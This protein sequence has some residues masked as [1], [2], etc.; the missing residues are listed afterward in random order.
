MNRLTNSFCNSFWKNKINNSEKRG[1]VHSLS[2]RAGRS[3]FILLVWVWIQEVNLC[4]TYTQVVCE[5]HEISELGFSSVPLE[6]DRVDRR[7][8]G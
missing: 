2:S 7:S 4:F 6:L 3:V 8:L 5:F 1:I